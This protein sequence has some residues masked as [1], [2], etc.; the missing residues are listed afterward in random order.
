MIDRQYHF[1]VY[2]LFCFL[3]TVYVIGLSSPARLTPMD[4]LSGCKKVSV[5]QRVSGVNL[6]DEHRVT[7]YFDILDFIPDQQWP[8][9]ES[10]PTGLEQDVAFIQ[11]FAFAPLFPSVRFLLTDSVPFPARHFPAPV[12]EVIA[13]P[14]QAGL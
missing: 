11:L 12:A 9:E 4:K 1:F 2:Q 5:H 13:P 3:M 10:E 8:A 14:P 6:P 7:H